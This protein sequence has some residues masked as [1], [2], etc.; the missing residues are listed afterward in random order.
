MEK[1][2]S[3]GSFNC[4]KASVVNVYRSIMSR[5]CRDTL[6][7]KEILEPYS[8]GVDGVG[9]CCGLCR[10][11][12]RLPCC[13]C[14]LPCCSY[15][16]ALEEVRRASTYLIIREDA[17]EFNK[18]KVREADGSGLPDPTYPTHAYEIPKYWPVFCICVVCGCGD[19][20]CRHCI[21][22]QL[23]FLQE[24]TDLS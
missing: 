15:P 6:I 18:A 21:K 10:A 19:Y 16:D 5:H 17:V 12:A 20:T 24:K 13:A 8:P 22:L 14:V 23:I 7:I 1:L 4:R 11:P 9:G 3:R 2:E